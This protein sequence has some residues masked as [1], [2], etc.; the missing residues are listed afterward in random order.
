MRAFRITKQPVGPSLG[1]CALWKGHHCSHALGRCPPH[2]ASRALGSRG[3]P[4]PAALFLWPRAR[5]TP[6]NFCAE[7][8]LGWMHTQPEGWQTFA[9]SPTDQKSAQSAPIFPFEGLMGKTLA[10]LRVSDFNGSI[11]MQMAKTSLAPLLLLGV[12]EPV[13]NTASSLAPVCH[14]L[15]V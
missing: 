2:R 9:L 3:A 7:Q 1:A 5:K 10:L 13:F 12:K 8:L 14:P 15:T 4:R 11:T 6:R